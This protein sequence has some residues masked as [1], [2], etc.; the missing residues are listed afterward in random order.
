MYL[1][2]IVIQ[3]NIA[4]VFLKYFSLTFVFFPTIYYYI[5]KFFLYK[6]KTRRFFLDLYYSCSNFY[7][8]VRIPKNKQTSRSIFQFS[9][10]TAK[11]RRVARARKVRGGRASPIIFTF[12]SVSKIKARGTGGEFLYSS[13]GFII[14]FQILL[15]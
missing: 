5:P 8:H 13:P 14:I 4:N 11:A 15:L 10:P 2:L 9:N 12:K 7:W 6:C 1:L 3:V